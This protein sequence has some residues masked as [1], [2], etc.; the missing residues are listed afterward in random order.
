QA[1]QRVMCN[2]IAHQL[3]EDTRDLAVPPELITEY[4][5]G[6]FLTLIRWQ[7]TSGNQRTPE[8]MNAIFQ[9]LVVPGLMATGKTNRSGQTPVQALAESG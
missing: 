3:A 2:A 6:A 8:E 4:L 9:T 1:V 7:L 5:A